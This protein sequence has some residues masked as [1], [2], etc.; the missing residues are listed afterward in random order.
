M[1]HDVGMQRENGGLIVLGQKTGVGPALSQ[2]SGVETWAEK[3]TGKE[4]IGR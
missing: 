1:R 2:K 3:P 4:Q